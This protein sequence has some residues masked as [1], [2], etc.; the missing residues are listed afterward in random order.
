MKRLA[1]VFVCLALACSAFAQITPG[2]GTSLS[3]SI[4]VVLTRATSTGSDLQIGPNMVHIVG[5]HCQHYMTKHHKFLFFGK[6]L[7]IDSA[8][9]QADP[10]TIFYE[11]TNHN[12]KTYGG[13][14]LI[15]S[16]LANTST[17]GATSNYL[18]LSTDSTAPAQSDCP[19]GSAA[20]SLT[21]ELT[22][23]GLARHQGTFGHTNGQSTLTLT[24]TWTDTTA[25]TSNIQK[26][27]VFNATSSGTMTFE[28]TFTPVSLNVGDQLQV[29][30]T[31][32]LS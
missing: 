21:S 12:L 19:A 18:A 15:A 9:C 25:G 26:A 1:L 2:E 27:A 24:Y 4:N 23:N 22:T 14:D 7:V 28:N 17:P 10:S 3:D 6:K 16:Q 13:I 32:T 29:T 5:R 20:C 31:V 8:A 11:E 30:W